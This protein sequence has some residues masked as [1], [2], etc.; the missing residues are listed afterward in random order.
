MLLNLSYFHSNLNH[1]LT[2]QS[3]DDKNYC[4]LLV[5]EFILLWYTPTYL[6]NSVVDVRTKKELQIIHTRAVIKIAKECSNYKVYISN[7][8]WV[9]GTSLLENKGIIFMSGLPEKVERMVISFVFKTGITKEISIV[10]RVLTS[11]NMLT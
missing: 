10:I 11:A 1:V 4:L 2:L 6:S 3:Y 8:K 5:S 7:L 9:V